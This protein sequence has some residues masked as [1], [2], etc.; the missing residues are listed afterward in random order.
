[1][2]GRCILIAVLSVLVTDIA[3]T[4]ESVLIK[5]GEYIFRASGCANCHT[6]TDNGGKFLAGGR[7]LS[8]PF[9][10]FYTPNIHPPPHYGYW[11]LDT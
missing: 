9:G 10:T 1:M 4:P 11:T 2:L 8:T 5:R 7:A 3:A 6:D